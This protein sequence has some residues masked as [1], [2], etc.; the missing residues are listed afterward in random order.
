[1]GWKR[2]ISYNIFYYNIIN[3]LLIILL[4]LIITI[5]IMDCNQFGVVIR[6]DKD[7][8]LA[9]AANY[10]AKGN[11]QKRDKAP[12][13]CKRRPRREGSDGKFGRRK[14]LDFGQS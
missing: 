12:R 1:M 5:K 7:G 4:K 10:V 9:K 2:L 3:L 11:S 14:I 13:F 6:N 8:K